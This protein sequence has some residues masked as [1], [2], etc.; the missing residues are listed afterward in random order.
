MGGHGD[1]VNDVA[2][3]DETT[4]PADFSSCNYTPTPNG[5]DDAVSFICFNPKGIMNGSSSWSVSFRAQI[6]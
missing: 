4:A 5:Y 6:D 2:F 3:S 1:A